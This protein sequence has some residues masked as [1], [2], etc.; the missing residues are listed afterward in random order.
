MEI[1][2][3]AEKPSTAQAIAPFARN[4]W[5]DADITLISAMPYINFR[6]KYPHGLTWADYPFISNPIQ[7]IGP[8]ENWIPRR[9]DKS[10]SIVPATITDEQFRNAD[11]IVFACDPDHTG[12]ASFEMLIHHHFE[13]ANRQFPAL[14]LL[15]LDGAS[16]TKAFVE[17]GNFRTDFDR[18]IRY[19]LAKRYFDWNWNINAM[20]IFG[21][22]LRSVGAPPD[23]PAVSKYALQL[24]YRINEF[25]A[26]ISGDET[27]TLMDKWP[28]TGRYPKD[29]AWRASF[30]SPASRAA[31]LTNLVEAG[32]L[33]YSELS[34][35]PRKLAASE[36]GKAFLAH[37]HPDCLD[38]DLPFRLHGW[39]TA[40][41]ELSK[42]SIDTYIRTF[43]GKQKRIH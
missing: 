9:I 3:V 34:T 2:V 29:E 28:G 22:A 12:A 14:R 31:I 7:H 26:P 18:Q 33:E 40:G 16:I 43:F 21:R 13:S 5:P 32:L 35:P 11:E 24:L 42:R 30:G 20:A 38:P 25:S 27:I 15:A 4:H 8:W 10:G 17:I 1:I 41:L 6:F 39:C 36:R 19:G 37:L 23:V